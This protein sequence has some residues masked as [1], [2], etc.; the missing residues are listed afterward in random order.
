[1]SDPTEQEIHAGTEALQE[2]ADEVEAEREKGSAGVMPDDDTLADD[3]ETR[4]DHLD[5]GVGLDVP[6]AA[7]NPGYGPK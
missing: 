6:P 7:A 5:D 3:G 1:M 2:I 4:E